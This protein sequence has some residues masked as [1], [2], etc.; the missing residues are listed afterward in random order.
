M[1]YRSP[2]TAAPSPVRCP[3]LQVR[4]LVLASS[5]PRRQDFLRDQG[6]DFRILPAR[7]EEVRPV[8]EEDPHGY[9]L[10][11]ARSKAENVR[12]SL[13]AE[14]APFPSRSGSPA[15][16]V[17]AADTIVVLDGGILGKP[18]DRSEA[19]SMLEHLVGRVHT[20]ITACCLWPAE[21]PAPC[22]E[23]ADSTDVRFAPW[24]R[25]LLE[26]YAA[27]GEPLDKA[28]AYGIQGKGAFLVE[29]IEGSWSTVVGLP[30]SRVMRALLD[31]GAL[32]SPACPAPNHAGT[33]ALPQQ[34]E[35]L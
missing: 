2:Q 3:F 30:V 14:L 34:G 33:T 29:R 10:R 19:V 24:P 23:F 15:P 21:D 9:V 5:S 18:A 12:S 13:M 16:L 35:P 26:A 11:T 20:V 17:L 25:E 22:A 27:T 31:C 1:E 6:L 7:T 8:P 32:L 4:P 28:G